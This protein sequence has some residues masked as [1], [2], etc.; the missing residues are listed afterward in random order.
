MIN[1][2]KQKNTLYRKLGTD[3]VDL[4]KA[5]RAIIAG[6]AIT[7]IFSE[8]D[9]NDYDIYF[10]SYEDIEVFIKNVFNQGEYL[11]ETKFVDLPRFSLVCKNHTDRSILFSS[12][13]GD[14]EKY[15][16]LIHF[17]FFENAQQIFESFDFHLNMGAFDFCTEEFVLDDNFLTSLTSRRI[18]F[19][20]NTKYPIIS[21][22]RVQKYLDRGYKI[23]KKEMFKIALAVNN[24][25][26]T[27]WE[28]LEDQMSGFYGVDVSKI[29]DKE[30]E[31]SLEAAID[32]LDLVEEQ[33]YPVYNNA[34]YNAY[35]LIALIRKEHNIPEQR[36]FYK[37]VR[38]Y[39]GVIT[40]P[41]QTQFKWELGRE[42]E[43]SSIG[44]FA[45]ASEE[46]ALDYSVHGANAIAEI[47][48][49]E[50]TEI[51]VDCAGHIV[52]RGPVVMETISIIEKT[53]TPSKIAQLQQSPVPMPP[54]PV[55]KT[56]G[57][58]NDDIPW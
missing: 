49:K 35:E 47:T 31:F 50:G 8:K 28:E 20:R 43:G 41:H 23:S 13:S 33:D 14:M 44:I 56:K 37:K 12:G 2:E 1:F 51:T 30:K 39:D 18:T 45:C 42:T 15:V 19:N 38:Y 3:I 55:Y 10:R 32:M 53:V 48:A 29:F 17:S 24:L 7:S 57:T 54:L 22:L 16:Q 4:L 25:T 52:L 40:S 5:S 9:I 34:I 21:T 6:G 11:P 46:E 27:S 58:N 36:T 26:I